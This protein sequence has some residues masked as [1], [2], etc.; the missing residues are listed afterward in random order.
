RGSTIEPDAMRRKQKPASLAQ[1]AARFAETG[2]EVPYMLEHLEGSDQVVFAVAAIERAVLPD[3]HFVCSIDVPAAVVRAG[4]GKPALI[5]PAAAA[6][7]E[8]PRTA[9]A[10]R[11]VSEHSA[12]HARHF[13][14]HQPFGLPDTRRGARVFVH[15][16]SA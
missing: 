10:E 6:E 14:H 5:G 2:R 4:V 7:I 11:R 9:Q 8:Y 1:G 3:A 13:P 12:Q 16:L 15:G